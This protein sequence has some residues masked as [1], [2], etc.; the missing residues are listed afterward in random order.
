MSGKHSSGLKTNGMERASRVNIYPDSFYEAHQNEILDLFRRG[1]RPIPVG[2]DKS[3]LLPGYNLPY[4]PDDREPL[5]WPAEWSGKYYPHQTIE[6]IAREFAVNFTRQSD[7]AHRYAYGIGLVNYP[8]TRLVTLDFDGKHSVGAWEDQGVPL[9]ATTL[10]QTRSG[11]W[12]AHFLAPDSNE[13]FESVKRSVRLIQ[14]LPDICDCKNADGSPHYCGIDLLVRGQC[15]VSPTPGYSLKRGWDSISPLPEA[16]WQFAL[17]NANKSIHAA[18]QCKNP[19]PTHRYDFVTEEYIRKHFS[20][21]NVS[22]HGNRI[23]IKVDCPK[24]DGQANAC[25]YLEPGNTHYWCFGDC[26]FQR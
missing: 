3:P 20:V 26:A 11:G 6:S 16:V 24:H 25:W 4:P 12:H 19:R 13:Q 23:E 8:A 7:G 1:F 22:H 10:E 9:P 2:Q 18:T 17:K 14:A 5:F 15:V 21:R